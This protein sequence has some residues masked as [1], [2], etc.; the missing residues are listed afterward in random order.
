MDILSILKSG[1][2]CS[3]VLLASRTD[4]A[5]V[6]VPR[7]ESSVGVFQVQKTLHGEHSQSHS[8]AVPVR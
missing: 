2:S 5:I 8:G 6:A 4:K 1:Q 3:A 7:M